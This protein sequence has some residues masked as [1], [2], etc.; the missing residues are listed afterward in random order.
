MKTEGSRRKLPFPG[1]QWPERKA[2]QIY[3][4]LLTCDLHQSGIEINIDH[5]F[6]HPGTGLNLSGPGENQRD[7]YPS[8]IVR[9]LSCP[10][11]TLTRYFPYPSIVGGENDQGI[12]TKSRP[13]QF[14]QQQTNTSV[15]VI[16]H[17]S[18]SRIRLTASVFFLQVLLFKGFFRLDGCMYCIIGPI[19]K[20]G[21]MA[22]LPHEP[23]RLFSES[24]GQVLPFWR[25]KVGTAVGCKIAIRMAP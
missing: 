4:R 25:L 1:K 23:K 12:F 24:V 11:G 2:I 5:R 3:E 13:V 6:F 20:K 15:Q 16:Y 17:R 21:P 10:E 18:I 8:F 22:V 7:P 19:Q 14:R 9:S